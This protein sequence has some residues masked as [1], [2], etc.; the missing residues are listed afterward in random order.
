MKANCSNC[1]RWNTG[2]F[3]EQFFT[4]AS[5]QMADDMRDDGFGS[6]TILM[7]AIKKAPNCSSLQYS[8]VIWLTADS[9]GECC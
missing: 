2:A 5:S 6:G 3:F 4:S 7:I 1:R 8:F 9:A